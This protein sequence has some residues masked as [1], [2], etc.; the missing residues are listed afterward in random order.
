MR[1]GPPPQRL[2]THRLAPLPQSSST[3]LLPRTPH[4]SGFCLTDGRKPAGLYERNGPGEKMSPPTLKVSDAI[5]YHIMI[6]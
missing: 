5:I 4:P 3:T 2:P 6:A 1:R